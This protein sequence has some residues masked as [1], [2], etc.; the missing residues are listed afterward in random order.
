MLIGDIIICNDLVGMVINMNKEYVTIIND[1]G[2]KLTIIN[3][4]E[5]HIIVNRYALCNLIKNKMLG[6]GKE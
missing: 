5:I 3:S 1:S 6:K 4:K 2:D